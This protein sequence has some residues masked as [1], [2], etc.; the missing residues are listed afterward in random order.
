V[1]RIPVGDAFAL[2]GVAELRG[3]AAALVCHPH[4]AF[5]GRLDTPLCVALAE[6]LGAAGLSTVRFNFRGLG[7]SGGVATGGNAEH[8]DV[9]AAAAWVRAAGA[10]RLALVG[11]SFGAMMALKAI[12]HGLLAEAYVAIGFPSTIIIDDGEREADVAQAL[13]RG[14]PSLLVQGDADPFCPLERVKAWSARRAHVR[15]EVLAGA[16]HFF[17]GAAERE[18]VGRVTR[19]VKEAL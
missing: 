5:G 18:L 9:A 4:P 3:E 14:I 19:F 16:G 12:A 10:R 7:A 15:V 11:Y 1:V 13:D 17:G 2:E 8:E 6:A